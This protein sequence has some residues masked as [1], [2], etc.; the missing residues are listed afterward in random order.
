MLEYKLMDIMVSKPL[1]IGLISFPFFLA[2]HI[3][4]VGEDKKID[5]IKI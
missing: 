1:L 2:L 5:V 3:W 4:L